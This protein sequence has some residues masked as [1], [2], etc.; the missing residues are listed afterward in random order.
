[1]LAGATAKENADAEF[2][3]HESVERAGAR[4]V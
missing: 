4:P 3:L 2:F 1:M